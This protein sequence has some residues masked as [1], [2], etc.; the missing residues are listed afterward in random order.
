[1]V[2][3]LFLFLFFIPSFRT[4]WLFLSVYS[5]LNGK[6]CFIHNQTFITNISNQLTSLQL[7]KPN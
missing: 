4:G 3:V 5:N 7:S 2:D 6:N 1:M